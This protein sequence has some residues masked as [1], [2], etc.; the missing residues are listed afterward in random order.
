MSAGRSAIKGEVMKKSKFG[1][2]ATGMLLTT[3]GNISAAGFTVPLQIIGMD[4]G[5]TNAL[6]LRFSA[7]TECGTPY[8]LVAAAQPYYKDIVTIASVAYTTQQD[9]RVWVSSCNSAGTA[10]ISRVAVGTVW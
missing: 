10:V 1:L 9:V 4:V 3:I 7:N 2:L 5:D 8:A 6:Y